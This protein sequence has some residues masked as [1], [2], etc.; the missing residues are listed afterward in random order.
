MKRYISVP[1]NDFENREVK[2][3]AEELAKL[4]MLEIRLSDDDAVQVVCE[5]SEKKCEYNNF[6]ESG[7][8]WVLDL[9][10]EFTEIFEN[11]YLLINEEKHLP[12]IQEKHSLKFRPRISGHENKTIRLFINGEEVVLDTI[13]EKK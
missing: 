8:I 12:K 11:S 7:K 13:E 3:K 9:V 10:D 2:T 4:F 6:Y 5:P 1:R